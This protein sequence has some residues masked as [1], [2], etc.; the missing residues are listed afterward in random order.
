[1]GKALASVGDRGAAV[2]NQ[3]VPGDEAARR[4]GEKHCSTGDLLGAADPAQRG[5]L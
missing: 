4:A 1:M 2:D 5:H 3:V